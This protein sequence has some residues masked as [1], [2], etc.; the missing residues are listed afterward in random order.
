MNEPPHLHI[1]DLDPTLGLIIPAPVCEVSAFIPD[2]RFVAVTDLDAGM[3]PFGWD[4]V[5]SGELSD[6]VTSAG[7][8]AQSIASFGVRTAMEIDPIGSP[9]EINENWSGMV[10]AHQIV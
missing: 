1:I 7:L 9:R 4:T 5:F 2:Q 8:L 10:S 6:N 3:T